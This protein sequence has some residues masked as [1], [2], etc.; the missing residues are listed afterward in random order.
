MLWNL[1]CDS[2]TLASCFLLCKNPCM[3]EVKPVIVYWN[4][5]E[6]QVQLVGN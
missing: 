5:S 2:Y 6:L 3:G 4:F 1:E